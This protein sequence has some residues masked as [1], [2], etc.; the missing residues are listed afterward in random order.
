MQQLDHDL[1]DL[2]RMEPTPRWLADA[3][4]HGVEV[5]PV[6]P[7]RA[8]VDPTA[9]WAS[10]AAPIEPLPSSGEVKAA[11]RELDQLFS[12]RGLSLNVEFNEP[13]FPGLP[14]LLER[15]GLA[16]KEREPLLLLSPTDFRPVVRPDVGVRFLSAAV[17]E[18]SLGSSPPIF[19]PVLLEQTC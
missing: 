4:S 9:S 13:L 12:Q 6:G 14:A 2:R 7:F 3:A 17:G 1:D 5:V 18:A 16:V 8:I 11:L 10:Y 15:E 19:R